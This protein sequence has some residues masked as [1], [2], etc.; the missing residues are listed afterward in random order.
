M[1]GSTRQSNVLPDI[2]IL[3]HFVITKSYQMRYRILNCS[4]DF[5]TLSLYFL[6]IYRKCYGEYV[7]FSMFFDDFLKSLLRKTEL[8][9][10]QLLV[11]LG[12]WP[13]SS[14]KSS[15]IPLPIFSWCGS[16]D[17]YDLVMPTYEMTE[18]VLQAQARVSVDI[19][20]VLG[21]QRTAFE[22][23]TPKVFFRGR[24]SNRIR[25]LL[26]LYSK[27]TPELVDAAITNFFFFREPADLERY[28]PTVQHTSIYDFFDYK[29]LISIDGTVAAYRVP[30]LLAGSSLLLK[31]KSKY[32]EHFY[33]LL[34]PGKHLLEL[35]EDLTDF[36]D[37]IQRLLNSSATD[38][39]PESTQ[40]GIVRE[41]N[42]II[43]DH[44]L[45]TNIYCYY[46]NLITQY[47][48]LLPHENIQREEG[49]E[50]V[51]N[52]NQHCDCGATKSQMKSEL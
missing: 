46:F 23:K 1:C 30:N 20:G 17:T 36:Y 39:I 28:G 40:M 14:R 9:D 45:P 3:I 48:K 27:R 49:D 37:I 43:L 51:L 19:L 29:Y 41:A 34:E 35:R 50:H 11:N 47:S 12:D 5:L 22:T 10:T 4:D 15:L 52:S 33:H 24:D 26:I 8:P 2:G 6:Q 25:L 38:H 13:L 31:Q 18:A 32:Y 7:G 16:S 44:V 21:Q 42:Q